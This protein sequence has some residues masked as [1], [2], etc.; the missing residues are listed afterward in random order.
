MILTIR[1]VLG[2]NNLTAKT[3]DGTVSSPI[4]KSLKKRKISNEIF[5]FARNLQIRT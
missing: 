4:D 5:L 2:V 1:N 3:S